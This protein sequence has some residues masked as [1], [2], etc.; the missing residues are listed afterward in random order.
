MES[1][2]PPSHHWDVGGPSPPFPYIPGFSI[3]IRPFAPPTA[4]D[5]QTQIDAEQSLKSRYPPGTHKIPAIEYC[6]A[7]PYC[8]PGPEQA[9][10]PSH[11]TQEHTLH[12]DYLITRPSSDIWWNVVQCY[13][14]DDRDSKY[15]AKIYDPVYSSFVTFAHMAADKHFN[16]EIKAYG[17]FKDAGI[18]GKLTPVLLGAW[19]MDVPVPSKDLGGVDYATTRPVPLLLFETVDAVNLA[20][21]YLKW[22]DTSDYVVRQ[23]QLPRS[24]RKEVIAKIYEAHALI[25][26]LGVRAES[27]PDGVLVR[28]SGLG[29]GRQDVTVFIAN[30]ERAHFP[31]LKNHISEPPEHAG[32]PVSPIETC[33]NDM[34]YDAE[35]LSMDEW[36]EPEGMDYYRQ[37]LVQRWG[38]STEYRPLPEELRQRIADGKWEE[39]SRRW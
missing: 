13:L 32:L 2:E 10:E 4:S 5:K 15:T 22:Y 20:N 7:K 35:W 25:S 21:T 30:F 8:Q 36:A 26:H 1:S 12:L 27:S 29:D 3:K 19:I 9:A 33:W 14:D 24:W 6:I 38:E 17:I 16:N 34:G 23:P 11:Q 37:W 31:E 18:S 39:E 28:T